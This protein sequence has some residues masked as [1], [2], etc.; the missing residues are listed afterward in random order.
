MKLKLI[1]QFKLIL[2]TTV[3]VFRMKVKQLQG[4]YLLALIVSIVSKRYNGDMKDKM[5]VLLM[6]RI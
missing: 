1:T 5:R 4:L 6:N 2:W 3:I